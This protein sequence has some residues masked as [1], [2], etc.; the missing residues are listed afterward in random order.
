[1]LEVLARYARAFEQMDVQAAKAVWPT[2]NARR[3]Q[4][5]F[6][7]QDAQQLRFTSCGVEISGQAAN[8]HCLGDAT[9]QPKI[10]AKSLHH[11][12]QKWYFDLSRH[13][14]EGWLIVNATVH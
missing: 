6:H 9:Y 14:D 4:R 8:A 11:P 7:Q 2:L 1:M 5:A 10:G 3:L 12:S 13:D